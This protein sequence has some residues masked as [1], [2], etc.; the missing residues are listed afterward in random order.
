MI[1]LG[2][3]HEYLGWSIYV[4]MYRVMV[5]RLDLMERDNMEDLVVDGRITLIRTLGLGFD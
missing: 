4:Y 1:R 2:H 3:V 5:W